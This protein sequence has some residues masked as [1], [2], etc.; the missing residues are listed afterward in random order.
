[1]HHYWEHLGELV[2]PQCFP[3]FV[4]E[5]FHYTR[6]PLDITVLSVCD[7]FLDPL[8]LSQL[9]V[10]HRE[11][12]LNPVAQLVV[13]L[14]KPSLAYMI[15]LFKLKVSLAHCSSHADPNFNSFPYLFSHFLLH[16]FLSPHHHLIYMLAFAVRQPFLP[17]SFFH[18]LR[19]TTDFL[20]QGFRHHNALPGFRLFELGHERLLFTIP[21][22]FEDLKPV[23]LVFEMLFTVY[24][25]LPD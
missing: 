11:R 15:D 25:D 14:S 10:K 13:A 22:N 20:T 16:Q 18:F 2:T 1:L 23:S 8:F 19:N 5:A 4:N 17:Y 21:Q 6:I 9:S 12:A 3:F 24:L 7:V